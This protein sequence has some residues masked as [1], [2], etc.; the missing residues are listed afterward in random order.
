MHAYIILPF[1]RFTFLEIYIVF[2]K[3]TPA[4]FFNFHSIINVNATCNNI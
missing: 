4:I 2:N 1:F 3:G